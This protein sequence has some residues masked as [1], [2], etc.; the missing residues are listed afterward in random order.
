M[1]FNFMEENMDGDIAVWKI[2]D[3]YHG[4][5]PHVV[6]EY[7]CLEKDSGHILET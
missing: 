3:L 4:T 2:Y 7:E 1:L 6:L 5:V